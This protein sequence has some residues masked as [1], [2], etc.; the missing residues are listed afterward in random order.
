MFL[1][2]LLLDIMLRK[3]LNY[4]T[5]SII[6]QFNSI[7]ALKTLFLRITIVFLNFLN[8]GNYFTFYS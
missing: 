5:G 8:W 3:C 1:S 6:L 2:V 7:F 4:D